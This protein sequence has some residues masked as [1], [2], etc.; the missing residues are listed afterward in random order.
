MENADRRQ[1]AEQTVERTRMGIGQDRQLIGR[2]RPVLQM[3]GQPEGYGNMDRL[4]DLISIDQAE[5]L[6]LRTWCHRPVSLLDFF[7][8]LSSSSDGSPIG[9]SAT[10]SKRLN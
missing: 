6:G 1:R 8:A 10:P 4:G 2:S 7:Y 9:A 3:I 5:R